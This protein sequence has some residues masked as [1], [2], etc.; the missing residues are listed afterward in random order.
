MRYPRVYIDPGSTALGWTGV[1]GYEFITCGLLRPPAGGSIVDCMHKIPGATSKIL[2]ERPTVYPHGN[3]KGDPNDLVHIALMGGVAAGVA[4]CRGGDTAQIVEV[5]PGA[6]KGQVEKSVMVE[7]ILDLLTVTERRTF[8]SEM[9][10]Q[11]IPP[12]LQHNVVDSIGLWLWDIE[13]L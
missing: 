3:A 10:T 11:R 2:I 1:D 7:R 5:Q 9:K 8:E 13:R 6:W 12:S 4:R